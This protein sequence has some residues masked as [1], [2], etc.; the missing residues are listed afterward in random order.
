MW[1]KHAIHSAR[2]YLWFQ[3][4]TGDLGTYLLWIRKVLLYG[5]G[6]KVQS[7]ESDWVKIPALLC[8]N[9][10]T[11]GRL[12]PTLMPLVF[13]PVMELVELPALYVCFKA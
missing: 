4:S 3:E 1:K 12:L 10:V 8:I 9:F 11:L 2:S 5:L 7:L 6:L 13:L